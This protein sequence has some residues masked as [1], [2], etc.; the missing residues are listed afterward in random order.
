MQALQLDF[1]A[2]TDTL[3]MYEK[4][5]KVEKS[6]ASVRRCLFAKNNEVK[7]EVGQIRTEVFELKERLNILER[8]ICV[9]QQKDMLCVNAS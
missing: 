9:T 4:I 5:E 2:G 7:V 3:H 1:F 6:S 8:Y